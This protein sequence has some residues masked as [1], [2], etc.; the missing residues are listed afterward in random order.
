[1]QQSLASG[2]SSSSELGRLVFLFKAVKTVIT[3]PY[4]KVAQTMQSK[5]SQV[6]GFYVFKFLKIKANRM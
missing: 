5:S 6:R 3:N 1:M 4:Q 2:R